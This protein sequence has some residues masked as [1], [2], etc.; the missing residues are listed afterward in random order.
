MSKTRH[1]SALER[2]AV[3]WQTIGLILVALARQVSMAHKQRAHGGAEKAGML[4]AAIMVAL[5]ELA[6][7]LDTVSDTPQSLNPRDQNAVEFL[8]TL[9]AL[10]GV[11]ALLIRQLGLNLRDLQDGKEDPQTLMI[12]A[13]VYRAPLAS[14][15]PIY[16]SS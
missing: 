8:K 12:C 5:V 11:L 4:E 3:R 2:L 7:E 14:P 1:L 9:Q 6:K 16:D 10:L 13:P 15:T